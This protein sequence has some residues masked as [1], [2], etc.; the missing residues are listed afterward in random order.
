MKVT[1]IGPNGIND[2]T[3]HVHATGCRDINGPKYRWVDDRDWSIDVQSKQELT[4]ILFSDFIGTD[5]T[6]HEDGEGNTIYTTWEDYLS[7][8]RIFPCVKGLK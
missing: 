2:A 7:E 3:F 6:C 4:E 8:T 5:E 1:V